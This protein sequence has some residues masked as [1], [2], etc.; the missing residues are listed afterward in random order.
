MKYP[1]LKDAFSS[2]RIFVALLMVLLTSTAFIQPVTFSQ[3]GTYQV[4]NQIKEDVTIDVPL[5][6]AA[7]KEAFSPAQLNVEVQVTRTEKAYD[8]YNL[9]V[10]TERF[11]ILSANHY[12]VITDMDGNIIHEKYIGSGWLAADVPA[13]MIGPRTVLVGTPTGAAIWNLDDNSIHSIP[14]IRG[15]HEFEYNERDDTFFVL[16]YNTVNIDGADYLY[17]MIVEYTRFGDE[18]WSLDTS[19]FIDPSQWCPYQDFYLGLPDITHSNTIFYDQEDDMIYYNS[20]NTNTFYKID[21]TTS[22]VLW[23]LGEYG[24]FDMYDY[25]GVQSDHIFFHTHAIERI[26]ESTFILFDNDYHN[27]TDFWSQ[28]SRMMEIDVD[29]VEMTASVSWVY[30]AP[31]SYYSSVWGDADRLPNGNRLGAFGTYNHPETTIGARLVEVDESGDIVWEMNFPPAIGVYYGVYRAE[32]IQLAPTLSSPKDILVLTDTDVDLSWQA[33]Y[34]FRPKRAVQASYS[35]LLNDSEID[36]GVFE[37]DEYWRPKDLEFSLGVLPEGGNNVTLVVE[38]EEG[39]FTLDTVFI[40]VGSFGLWRQGSTSFETGDHDTK[41]QWVGLTASPLQCTITVDGTILQDFEWSGTDIILDLAHFA[42]GTHSIAMDLTNVSVLVHSEVFYFVIYPATLPRLVS[43][44]AYV[45]KQWDAE[46]LL[47]WELFDLHPSNWTIYVDGIL[48]SSDEWNSQTLILEWTTP[49]LELGTHWITLVI[50]DKA[51]HCAASRIE[52]EVLTPTPPVIISGPVTRVVEWGEENVE[53]NWEIRGGTDWI[54][55]RNGTEFLSGDVTSNFIVTEIVDWLVE[56]WFIGRYNL[57]L[58]VSDNNGTT[59][60]TVWLRVILDPGDRYAD[61]FLPDRSFYYLAGENA[62]GTPDGQYT[63]L[64]LDY[65]NGAITL[66][67]GKHEEIVDGDGNDFTIFAMGNYTV[68]TIDDIGQ[69]MRFISTGEDTQSFDLNDVG[70]EVARY[71]KVEYLRGDS[72]LL[73]AVEAVNCIVTEGDGSPPIIEG[74]DDTSGFQGQIISLIW[75]AQDVTPFMMRIYANDTLAST[76]AWSSSEMIHD[77]ISFDLGVWNITAEF[78]DLFG[79]TASD[80]V[81]VEILEGAPPF[82]TGAIVVLA[83]GGIGIIALAVFAMKR[84]MTEVG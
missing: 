2:H 11:N 71:V 31:I 47:T 73:D 75:E 9:F 56:A 46:L 79:N 52:L 72:V 43:P 36:S 12:A 55:W 37:Y 69:M 51:G 24:D 21:H 19:A 67:M 64:F 53:V 48:Q 78:W 58:Q 39:H 29:E 25:D 54:L 4:T 83:G 63:A 34:N 28:K 27:Q 80:S 13:E 1:N 10:L 66:D 77:F 18:V 60:S 65:E 33:W 26:D 20:R 30:T 74:P 16:Q 15:H 49:F 7:P 76:Y 68:S 41:I 23:G 8:G 17:D 14:S 61:A 42:A 38:D 6:D 44:P 45:S 3:N 50:Q 82:P 84:R 32:R 57:T 81:L 22:E 62:L 70:L 40:W 5:S 35:L 59:S